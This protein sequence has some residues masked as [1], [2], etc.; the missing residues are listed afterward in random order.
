MAGMAF[1]KV[2]P[3]PWFQSVM[4]A[5]ALALLVLALSVVALALKVMAVGEESYRGGGGMA[6]PKVIPLLWFQSVMLGL[7][8]EGH[9]LGL[10]THV[11]LVSEDTYVFEVQ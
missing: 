2:I 6:S 11:R 3:L 9:G 5:L 4:L 1:P 10:G 8:L 7:G